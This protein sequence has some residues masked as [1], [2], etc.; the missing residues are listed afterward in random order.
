[1]LLLHI[2]HAVQPPI[3]PADLFP[4]VSAGEKK[5]QA[6]LKTNRA[7]KQAKLAAKGAVA[8]PKV[9]GIRVRKGVRVKVSVCMWDAL[10]QTLGQRLL[11]A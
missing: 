10:C 2:T 8:K 11:D 3:D 1:M 4:R 6:D 7:K 9:K 5:Q